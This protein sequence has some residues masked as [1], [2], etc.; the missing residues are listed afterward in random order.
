MSSLQPDDARLP[1]IRQTLE[2]AL[3]ASGPYTLCGELCEQRCRYRLFAAQ[4]TSSYRHTAGRGV[5][6]EE[7]T[8]AVAGIAAR[9]EIK[10]WGSE[11]S[12]RA[13]KSF[14]TCLLI[15]LAHDFDRI[16]TYNTV[17]A[18]RDLFEQSE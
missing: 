1:A 13:H 7:A 16:D 2:R 3:T 5:G 10:L 14:R 12:T 6:G 17:L 15:H 9:Q 18:A 4:L 11:V 8:R